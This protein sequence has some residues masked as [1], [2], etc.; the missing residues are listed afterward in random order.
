PTRRDRPVLKTGGATG[1]LPSPRACLPERART[2]SS[3][4]ACKPA[5]GKRS[6]D[7]TARSVPCADSA[8]APVS[9]VTVTGPA[10]A[11]PRFRKRAP[12]GGV[13]E[14]DSVVPAGAG[15]PIGTGVALAKDAL[16]IGVGEARSS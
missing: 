13:N 5:H 3:S 1:P 6:F 7:P 15:A 8:A 11:A 10:V 16:E 4:P 2:T 14:S 12:G 9:I